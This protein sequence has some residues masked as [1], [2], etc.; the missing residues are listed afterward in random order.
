MA[1]VERGDIFFCVTRA[2]KEKV[3]PKLFENHPWLLV[4][5]WE[6]FILGFI[7]MTV[8]CKS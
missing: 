8:Q 1:K 4:C 2:A 6:G 5:S 3:T 7:Y